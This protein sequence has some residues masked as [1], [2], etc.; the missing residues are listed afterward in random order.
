MKRS[1]EVI[2]PCY[3]PKHLPGQLVPTTW[4]ICLLLNNLQNLMLGNAKKCFPIVKIA[5]FASLW[6]GRKKQEMVSFVVRNNQESIKCCHL[7][8]V[9]F[10]EWQGGR[11][12]RE[13]QVNLNTQ[14]PEGK[15]TAQQDFSFHDVV[16]PG[17]LGDF[18]RSP[19]TETYGRK[20]DNTI[21]DFLIKLAPFWWIWTESS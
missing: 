11:C 15:T 3:C 13:E 6:S 14:W 16:F 8:G 18:C 10:S 20:L 12:Y 9:L 5:F 1:K 7:F 4:N 2:S 21:G 17:V 19:A